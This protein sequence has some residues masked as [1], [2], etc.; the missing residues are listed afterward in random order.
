MAIAKSTVL[1]ASRRVNSRIQALTLTTLIMTQYIQI[2]ELARAKK[3]SK[4]PKQDVT[5]VKNIF[6][7]LLLKP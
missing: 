3:K 2:I 7:I 6:I 4:E 5:K 1:R